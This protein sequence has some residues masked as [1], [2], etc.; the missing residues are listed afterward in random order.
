MAKLGMKITPDIV[1]IVGGPVW[2]VES[3]SIRC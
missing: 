1:I 3:A 2:P